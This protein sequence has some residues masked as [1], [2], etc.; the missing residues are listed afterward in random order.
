MVIRAHTHGASVVLF[1]RIYVVDVAAF[2]VGRYRGVFES[3]YRKVEWA[4]LSFAHRSGRG[5]QSVILRLCV[6]S[7][8]G[9]CSN[10]GKIN[11]NSRPFSSNAL[12]ALISLVSLARGRL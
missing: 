1:A 9:Y 3:G 4:V 6:E 8:I 7:F 5:K 10:S 12:Q 11:L 2:S